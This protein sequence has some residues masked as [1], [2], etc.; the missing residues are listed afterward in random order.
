MAMAGFCRNCGTQLG[1]A[2]VFCVNC[3]QPM[4]G[5]PAP[6]AAAP[7]PSAQG[8]ATAPATATK[9]S[10][11]VKIVLIL[12]A[13]LFLFGAL[14]IGAVVYVGYR[15][16]QKAREIG[17]TLPSP[18]RRGHESAFRGTNV[19]GWLSKEEVSAAVRMEVVRM[20]AEAG[21][22]PGCT[23]LVEGDATELTMKH[24]TQLNNK[25]MSKSDQQIM[26][27]FG[28]TILRG[29]GDSGGGSSEHPGETPVLVFNVDENS[30]LLQMKLTKGAL[31]GMGPGT[32]TIA[33]LGDEAFDAGGAVLMVR[34]GD[35]MVRITYTTC[36]CGLDDI[37]PLARK[38]VGN[39]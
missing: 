2:Q 24:A 34:K 27:N 6:P 5:A 39:L 21:E 22:N 19:C 18:D 33:N 35:K 38:L 30:A 16:R 32:A 8:A 31:S 14:G 26:E 1:D 7:A 37:L 17:L 29:S 20:E 15:V 9:G 11:V 23:Y 12:V 10:P 28:K 25:Q 4:A 36:P 13:V 3:G